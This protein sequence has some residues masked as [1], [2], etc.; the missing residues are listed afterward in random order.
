MMNWL[1]VLPDGLIVAVFTGFFGGA[2]VLLPYLL[3]IFRL[4]RPNADNTDFILR[5]QSSLFAMT[6]F[7]LAFTLVQAQGNFR[8][9]EGIVLAEAAQINT[10]DRLLTRYGEESVSAIRP[11]LLVYAQSIVKDEWPKLID[12]GDSAVTARAFVPVAQAIT[13]INASSGR[14][15]SLY[16]EM[17]KSLDVIAESRESRIDAAK[18]ALPAVYWVV[19]WLAM[20][21]LVAA[22]CAVVRTSF[23]TFFLAAQA[24]ILGAFI[25]VVFITD[26]PFKGQTSVGP[27]A[28]NKVIVA[29]KTRS[30]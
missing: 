14:Q 30:S 25:G 3:A 16:S 7:A 29:I 9:V 15:T 2:V 10:L 6:A 19:V 27:D 24:A 4:F 18:I 28:L 12:E 5:I 17:L 13:A 8:R 21:V 20:G 26:H 22:S 1:Y 23:R 11:S